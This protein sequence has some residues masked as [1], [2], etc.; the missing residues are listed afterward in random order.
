MSMPVYDQ[1]RCV[2]IDDW[3]K[4]KR[5]NYGPIIVNADTGRPIDL[6]DSRDS[7]DVIAWLS[8][9]KEIKYVIRDRSPAYASAIRNAIPE[10]KKIADR[11]HLVKKISDA[12]QE[13]NRQE[14]SFLR[15]LCKNIYIGN[16]TNKSKM[17]PSKVN[18]VFQK[19]AN[20]H[21]P[22]QKISPIM[23]KKREKLIQI[24]K[25]K[26]SR[27]SIFQIPRKT[28]IDR[29]TV[30][31]CLSHGIPSTVRSTRVDYIRYMA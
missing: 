8:N 13:E 18:L 20:D 9:H 10:A 4:R 15:K 29:M 28:Q 23:L 2:G 22:A 21:I 19:D 11:F 16:E 25:M 12:A 14:Y 5:M 1:L 17:K 7:I 24:T 27:H 6:L 30:K 3:A 26:K 31:R